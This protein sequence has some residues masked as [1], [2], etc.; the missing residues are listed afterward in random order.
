MFQN[1][2][3][4][5]DFRRKLGNGRSLHAGWLKC[6]TKQQNGELYVVISRAKEVIDCPNFLARQLARLRHP[7]P[8]SASKRWSL[9]LMMM[10]IK[11]ILFKGPLAP[12]MLA[13]SMFTKF[14]G[15]SNGPSLSAGSDTV[16][17]KLFSTVVQPTTSH[18]CFRLFLRLPPAYWVCSI[19][20]T[21]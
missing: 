9:A 21:Y 8:P 20:P 7:S 1:G 17:K 5:P 6:H 18:H 16:R 15:S 13:C 10:H 3:Q 19:N 11:R 12:F 4:G 14:C 2:C